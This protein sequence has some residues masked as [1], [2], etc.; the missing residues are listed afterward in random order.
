MIPLPLRHTCTFLLAGLVLV[1]SAGPAIAQDDPS[2]QTREVA[3]FTGI[4]FSVPGTVHLRQGEP[5][6]VEV[7]GP[8]KVLDRLETVVE[9]GTLHVR[10][11]EE[12][13]WLDWFGSDVDERIDVYVTAPTI[14]RLSVAGSGDIVGET[15][16]QSASLRLENAGSGGFDLAVDADEV[17]L[18][19]AGSGDTRLR[20]RG[21]DLSVD[22]AGSGDVEAADLE[23]AAVDVRIAGSGN[24]R[25]HATN[26][27]SA[28]IMGSGDV[29]Y[30]G[31]PEIDSSVLGS[32][33][34]RPLE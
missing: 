10:S 3:S 4:G 15:P 14:E 30:R 18:S 22:I 11:E 24:V 6:S 5:Q 12:R 28:Q 21:G 23:A 1:L 7:E 31:Q 25:V 34:V 32:G 19:I 16:I 13:S 33:G 26:R 17:R 27:I 29:R 20:G 2:R 9:D 8:A